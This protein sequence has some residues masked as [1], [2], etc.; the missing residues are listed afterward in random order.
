MDLHTKC[1]LCQCIDKDGGHLLFKCKLIKQVCHEQ[2]LEKE[3]VDLTTTLSV[4]GAVEYVL[5]AKEESQTKM[6]VLMWSRWAK[7]SRVREEDMSRSAA[8]ITHSVAVYAMEILKT[9]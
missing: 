6:V 8:S 3:Q 4:K 9:F 2:Y 1:I 5:A 7:R